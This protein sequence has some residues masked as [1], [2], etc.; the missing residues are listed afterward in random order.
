MFAPTRATVRVPATTANLGPGFD[1]MGVALKLYNTVRVTRA[2]KDAAPLAGMFAETAAAFF[3]AAKTKPFP[4]SVV[5]SGA[6]PRAR[7]LGSSVTVRL[8]IAAGLNALAGAP[9]PS[10]A[11]LGLVVDLEGHPDNAVPAFHGGFASCA[12]GRFFRAEVAPRLKFVGLV[13]GFELETKK[14]RAVLPR[15]VPLADAIANLQHGTLIA[16]A[17]AQK[18]YASLAGT[19]E[20]RWHQPF[21]APLLPG[22]E[23]VRAAA[24]KAGA[25]GFYLSGAGSTLMALALGDAQARAVARRMEAAARKT[26]MESQSFVVSADN[27]GTIVT[28]R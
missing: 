5:I 13:P 7:G 9:L 26:G 16:L 19:F 17:F 20:D 14:A 8:G 21:R 1:T 28:V 25:L 11:V 15:R 27:R 3:T 23:A 2:G 10:A 4:I 12:P 24:G 22:W 18:D 6:V